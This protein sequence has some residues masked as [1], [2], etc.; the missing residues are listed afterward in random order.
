MAK[1]LILNGS[2]H[3]EGHVSLMLETFKSALEKNDVK[4]VQ[5]NLAFM[6]I[7]D[8]IG[9]TYPLHDDMEDVLSSL[10]E[11]DY[12]V[13]ASPLY[14][15]SFSGYLKCALDRIT[16]SPSTE[17]KKLICLVS[18]GGVDEDTLEPLKK[19]CELISNHL[20]WE[21]LS[22]LYIKDCKKPLNQSKHI[23]ELE[24]VYQLG[25]KIK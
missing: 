3:L 15:F 17:N 22:F 8:S 9:E 25:L 21:L 19:Q 10:N 16:Y 18:M 20:K 1:V 13:F 11:C 14:Y 5:Y 23:A 7:H 24:R 4:F 6:N 2:P 12:V